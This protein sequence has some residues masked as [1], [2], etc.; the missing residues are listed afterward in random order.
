MFIIQSNKTCLFYENTVEA[1]DAMQG[2]TR[3][4]QCSN[5]DKKQN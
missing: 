5:N 1:T 3:N 4:L 2:K